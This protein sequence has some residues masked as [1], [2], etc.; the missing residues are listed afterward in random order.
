MLYCARLG[1]FAS[2]GFFSLSISTFNDYVMSAYL[3]EFLAGTQQTI[4]CPIDLPK[5]ALADVFD[6]IG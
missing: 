6:F 5:T 1:S 3:A 4:T 2:L